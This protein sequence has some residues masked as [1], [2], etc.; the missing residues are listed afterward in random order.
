MNLIILLALIVLAYLITKPTQGD[1]QRVKKSQTG[2]A[3][4]DSMQDYL[5][6]PVKYGEWHTGTSP[7]GCR[8]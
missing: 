7:C 1:V 8:K 4:I 5:N 3:Y 2:P 6:E